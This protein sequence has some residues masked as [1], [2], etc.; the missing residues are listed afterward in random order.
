MEKELIQKITRNSVVPYDCLNDYWVIVTNEGIFA[1]ANGR[2]FH[3]TK[4]QA[5]KHWYN[6]MRWRAV[7]EYNKN[8]AM[9][10]NI[11][12]NS[13]WNLKTDKSNREIWEDF[14]NSSAIKCCFNIIQW[15]DA[16]RNVCSQSGI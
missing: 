14:K 16:K 4:E 7:S 9:L 13:Y 15:K 12:R 6:E 1:P 11:N 2:M 3:E 5:W 10:H 8:Y